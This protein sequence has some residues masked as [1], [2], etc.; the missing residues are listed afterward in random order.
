[1]IRH[2]LEDQ[3]P[4]YKAEDVRAGMI[5]LRT[6]LQRMLF[7]LGLVALMALLV[8]LYGVAA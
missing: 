8:V 1:M 4:H 5:I 6:R 3:A 2:K 7:G